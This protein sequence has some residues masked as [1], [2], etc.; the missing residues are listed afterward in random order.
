MGFY[1]GMKPAAAEKGRVVKVDFGTCC[2]PSRVAAGWF[3]TNHKWSF[4]DGIF[5]YRLFVCPRQKQSQ[6]RG[7]NLGEHQEINYSNNFNK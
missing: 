1:K 4:P 5:S 3:F 7:C 2:H 6:D